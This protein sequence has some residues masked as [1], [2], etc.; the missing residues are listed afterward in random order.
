MGI[1]ER[2]ERERR[3][4][5][6]D[7]LE[8]AKNVFSNKGYMNATIEEIAQEAE[9]STGTIYLYFSGKEELY[10]SLILESYDILI[11][12]VNKVLGEDI[13]KGEILVKIARTYYRFCK[14][15]PDHY[16][17]LNFIVNEHFN[18]KLASELI[19]KIGEKTDMIFKMVS[20]VIKTGIQE[21]IFK[22]VN[23]LDITSLFWSNLHGIIQV[24]TT[25]DY[26]KSKKTDV[27]TLITKNIE[28]IVA[29]IK[30]N[31]YP[32]RNN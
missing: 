13:D 3:K 11:S 25:I 10:V 23:A 4:R 15:Y 9:L 19:E 24:Q 26:L 5:K 22:P 28:L 27:E 14:N 1:P 12:E 30:V 7:I 18:L 16:R 17:V 31:E 32:S 29:A 6:K 20:G 2:K 8:A 21:G